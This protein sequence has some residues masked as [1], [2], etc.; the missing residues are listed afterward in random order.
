[1]LVNEDIWS[2]INFQANQCYLNMQQIQGRPFNFRNKSFENYGQ[3][4]QNDTRNSVMWDSTI[5]TQLLTDVV[6]SCTLHV[7][8]ELNI[9]IHYLIQP[10]LNHNF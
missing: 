7:N 4:M 8:R 9:N 10:E 2:K 6:D 5:M 3:H 1:M